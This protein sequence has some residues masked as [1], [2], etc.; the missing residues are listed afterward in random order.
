VVEQQTRASAERPLGA[1]DGGRRGGIRLA[2]WLSLVPGAGQLY[3]REGRK[4]A[5][6]FLGV[7]ALFAL[8]LNIPAVTDALIGWWRPRGG[9]AVSLSL[10]AQM[11]SLLV[12][13]GFFVAALA[14]WYA[15]MHD[16]RI[17]ARARAGQ[18]VRLG[19]WWFFHR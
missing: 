10:A 9:L 6:F 7:I 2:T 11:F 1:A 12:F 14:F 19:R 18:P 15:A 5:A 13:V 17:T 8:S 3:N 16:A 4:A